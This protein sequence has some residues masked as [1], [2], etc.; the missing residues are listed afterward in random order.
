MSKLFP[1]NQT[2]SYYEY[3][4]VETPISPSTTNHELTKSFLFFRTAFHAVR[5][6]KS[7]I[8]CTRSHSQ[9]L[10]LNG[11]F[12]PHVDYV[13]EMERLQLDLEVWENRL[14]EAGLGLVDW[15]AVRT[16]GRGLPGEILGMVKGE[17]ET[18][19]MVLPKV[20]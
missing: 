1:A 19:V 8:R 6:A 9:F 13:A 11:D 10:H 20:W 2:Q 16:L 12:N 4:L 17:L 14:V 3:P 7:L 18:G 15:L 5:Q